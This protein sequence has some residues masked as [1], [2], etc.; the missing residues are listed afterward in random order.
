MTTIPLGFEVGTG[1]AVE[2]PIRH[3][4]V[5]GQTQ[6]AGKTTA[7]EGLIARS[8]RRALTF[9]TKRGEGAFQH[10]RGIRPYFREQAREQQVRTG[11]DSRPNPSRRSRGEARRRDRL[12][13]MPADARRARS[14]RIDLHRARSTSR[15]RADSPVD[16]GHGLMAIAPLHPCPYPH[17]R[18]LTRSSHCAR[19]TRQADQRANV[20]VRRWYRTARWATLRREL[21]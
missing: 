20:D 5:C 14:A 13:P 11:D 18:R 8:G 21:L 9:V 7:L 4:A 15:S 19:H 6:E 10:A 3:M 17:C 2:M 12:W 1:H 16:G